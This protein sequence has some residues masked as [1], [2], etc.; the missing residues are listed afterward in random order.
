MTERKSTPSASCQIMFNSAVR[1]PTGVWRCSCFPVEVQQQCVWGVFQSKSAGVELCVF[2]FLFLSR[3]QPTWTACFSTSRTWSTCPA[4]SSACWTR[5]GFSPDTPTSCRRCVS[6]ATLFI[7]FI[8]PPKLIS[9]PC[10]RMTTFASSLWNLSP[11]LR[12]AGPLQSAKFT[13]V[14]SATITKRLIWCDSALL[15]LWSAICT[16]HCGERCVKLPK[17]TTGI[18]DAR[19]WRTARCNIESHRGKLC[20]LLQIR[21]WSLQLLSRLKSVS[22][23]HSCGSEA[24]SQLTGSGATEVFPPENRF[25]CWLCLLSTTSG[26]RRCHSCQYFVVNIF[27]Q[28]EEP[29]KSF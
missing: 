9:S 29:L 12:G 11:V 8:S 10:R 5:S 21:R 22:P 17:G 19:H 27:L 20:C 24:R 7:P 13:L 6:H 23:F 25:A 2:L 15:P 18:N 4:V 16:K 28:T 26:A 14:L 3:L 1:Q